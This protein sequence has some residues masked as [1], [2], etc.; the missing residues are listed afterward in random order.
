M[1][2]LLLMQIV[3]AQTL[4]LSPYKDTMFTTWRITSPE[5]VQMAEAS[6]QGRNP[7]V[8]S[9]YPA[10]TAPSMS[11][12]DPDFYNLYY[13]RHLHLAVWDEFPGLKARDSRVSLLAPEEQKDLVLVF[14]SG[15]LDTIEVGAPKNARFAVIFIHGAGGNKL[16]GA[17]DWMFGGNFNRLKN[18]AVQ[19]GGVYYSPS[20]NL[21]PAGATPIAELIQSLKVQ[22]PLIQIVLACASA[23]G[24]ICAELRNDINLAGIIYLGTAQVAPD[25]SSTSL[26][27][28]KVP[29]VFAHGS[30]DPVMNWETLKKS[31]DELKNLDPQYPTRFYLFHGGV[32]G[33]PIRMMDWREVLNFIFSALSPND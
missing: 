25:I 18:L 13:N 12:T 16:L 4:T 7:G 29:I 15:S 1:I 8:S 6:A 33:T 26:A 23:G 3:T 17:N 28:H 24:I 11:W 21:T 30:Y 20:V 27:Q 5:Q 19:N 22:S 14:P 2:F 32:H 9:V 10:S 31:Y